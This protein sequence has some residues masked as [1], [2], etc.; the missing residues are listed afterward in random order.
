MVGPADGIIDDERRLHLLVVPRGIFVSFVV[1]VVKDL[2]SM[3]IA[4]GLSSS[5]RCIRSFFYHGST[6]VAVIVL[7]HVQKSSS[8]LCKM[9]ALV[10]IHLLFPVV[11]VL[12][13]YQTVA[14]SLGPSSTKSRC[15]SDD[16]SVPVPTSATPSPQRQQG[17]FINRKSSKVHLEHLTWKTSRRQWL[18]AAFVG[19]A[20]I[21]TVSQPSVAAITDETDAFGDNWWST[22][23]TTTVPPP[24]K[25]DK[26][27]SPSDEIVIQI[28]KGDLQTKDGLGLELGEVEFRTN[29]RVFIKSVTPGSIAERLGIK[30]DWVVVSINGSVRGG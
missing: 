2:S 28:P 30:K 5:R 4:L 9:K 16:P 13:S 18:E 15:S 11:W 12:V 23:T 17:N 6:I 1:D 14:L 26:V 8:T 7:A 21:S 24:I 29:R 10:G 27:P 22:G 20:S 3:M 25:G 19:V